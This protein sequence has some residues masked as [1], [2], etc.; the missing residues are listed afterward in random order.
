MP[1]SKLEEE[2]GEDR[3]IASSDSPRGSDLEKQCAAAKPRLTIT[4]TAASFQFLV[5]VLCIQSRG[6]AFKS[7]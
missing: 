1:G 3:T 2:T 4:M 6:A 5:N 7:S